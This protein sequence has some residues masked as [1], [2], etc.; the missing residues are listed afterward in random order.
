[1]DH[2][3]DSPAMD[4]ALVS[5]YLANE[6]SSAERLAFER[7][8]EALPGRREE[9]VLIRRLW[10]DAASIPNA[11]A[12]DAMWRSL[13]RKL[14]AGEP[15]S[16]GSSRASGES[17]HALPRRV[18]V[19]P[20]ASAGSHWKQAVALA[21]ATILIVVLALANRGADDRQV[22]APMAPAKEFR[23]AP[24]QRA[25]IQLTDGSRVEL[26]VASR[27]TVSAFTDSTRNVT[28]EGEAMFDVE[29]DERRPFRVRSAGTVTE[30]LGTRFGVRAYREDTVVRVFVTAGAV[31]VR[32]DSARS[33][34]TL[35]VAG[36]LARLDARG[37]VTV[38]TDV[39][40]ARYLAWTRSRVVLRSEPLRDAIVEI[41]RWHDV[42]ITIPD[43]RVARLR[44][45]ADMPLRSLVETLNAV[46]IPLNLRYRLT[47]E[48]AVIL[49]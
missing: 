4:W 15:A 35:L 47:E 44:I 11:S 7:W 41:G 20:F 42:V 46:T 25:T 2:S 29:H 37:M 22:V 10:H 18:T 8:I 36:Q 33:A 1:M 23:T 32:G 21:A 3:H 24:G 34:P 40:T 16:D 19:L 5:R 13:S 31:T 39:D 49:R 6:L 48:G 14:G 43:E 17:A 45:T 28:L 38:E 9:M 27:L 26:G 30:D 12:V